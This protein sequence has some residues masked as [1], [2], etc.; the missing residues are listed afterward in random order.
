M[1]NNGLNN[2]AALPRQHEVIEHR[3]SD[4]IKL[5]EARTA[6]GLSRYFGS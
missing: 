3:Y 4:P 6:C 5:R 2:I 1:K